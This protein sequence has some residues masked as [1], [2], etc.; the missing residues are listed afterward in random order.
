[1]SEQKPTIELV[2][3]FHS[4]FDHPIAPIPTVGTRELREL[5]IALIAEELSELCVALQV[6][7]RLHV[8]IPGIT[9]G[10]CTL[11]VNALENSHIDL[12]EAADALGDIDYVVAGTNLALGIPADKVIN[13]IH[14]SNMSK[15]GPDGI[16]LRREDGK[17]LKGPNYTPPQLEKIIYPE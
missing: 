7:L 2:R 3:E 5:R 13:E 17:I 11:K 6:E 8:F 12:V 15:N 10:G 1:M 4:T 14:R 9:P 16:P